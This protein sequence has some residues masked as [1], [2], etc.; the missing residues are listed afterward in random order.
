MQRGLKELIWPPM[1]P[2]CTYLFG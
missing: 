1:P 2:K